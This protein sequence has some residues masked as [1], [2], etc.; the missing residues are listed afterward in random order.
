MSGLNQK[1]GR[2]SKRAREIIYKAEKQLLQYRVRCINAML[3]DNRKA[4]SKCR[5]DLVSRVTNT[6]DRHKFS[7]FIENVSKD[8]FTKVKERQIRKLNSLINKTIN[9][10]NGIS[11]AGSNHNNGSGPNSQMQGIAN[12]N[13]AGNLNNNNSELVINLSKKSLTK[14]QESLL[15][16]GP[17][18]AL[19]PSNI[20]STDYITVVES[21]CNKLKEKEVQELRAD[22]NSLLRR[23]HTPKPNLTKQERRGIAQLKKDKDRLVLTADKGVAMVVIDKKD[24]IHKAKEL[25]GQLA[26]RKLDRDPT[27]RIKV[28]LITK[29]KTIKKETRLDEGMHKIMYLTSCVPPKFLWIT[30][31]P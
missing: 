28:K 11:P 18:F 19:A 30:Q 17:N 21:I 1:A 10:N 25:L 24:Y 6:T 5:S 31:N 3:E 9:R 15:A 23:V 27:S 8:R 7:K 29:L 2:A 16:K 14:A 20:P 12:N 22:V 4:I 26:Y 13:Q